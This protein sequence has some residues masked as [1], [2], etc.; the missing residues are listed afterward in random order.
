MPA[1]AIPTA[2]SRVLPLWGGLPLWA[3]LILA[4]GAGAGAAPP[5]RKSPPSTIAATPP[6]NVSAYAVPL[7]TLQTTVERG[8]TFAELSIKTNRAA[9][10]TVV[11][12]ELFHDS[13]TAVTSAATLDFKGHRAQFFD[14][15][16]NTIYSAKLIAVDLATNKQVI[17]Y[18]PFLT[19]RRRVTVRF[20]M[21][22]C[23]DDSDDFSSGELE[24]FVAMRTPADVLLDSDEMGSEAAPLQVPSG[25]IFESDLSLRS[26]PFDDTT[27]PRLAV[28][29][30][31][32][33]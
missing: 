1:I 12:Y 27:L 7:L 15:R 14:L 19:L 24:I 3:A 30:I 10:I 5:A 11:L 28:F 33:F 6:S 29:R 17:R 4:L 26:K 13:P 2:S 9:A 22:Y 25:D 8:G 18:E 32:G 21:F 23:A 20:P 16:P 31:D